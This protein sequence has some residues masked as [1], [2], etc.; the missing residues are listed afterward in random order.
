MNRDSRRFFLQRGTIAAAALGGGILPAFA[1]RALAQ[2]PRGKVFIFLFLRGA[3]DGLS[4][5][6]PRDE[7]RLAHLRPQ[8]T[9]PGL[10]DIGGFSLPPALEPLLPLAMQPNQFAECFVQRITCWVLHSQSIG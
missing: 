9:P 1:R 6:V 3:L 7:G 5:V 4:V 8:L 2:E 10:L